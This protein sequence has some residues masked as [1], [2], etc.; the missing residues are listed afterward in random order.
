M[1]SSPKADRPTATEGIPGE[2]DCIARKR[3]GGTR[4]EIRRGGRYF[5]RFEFS[6]SALDVN[7]AT[8]CQ[9]LRSLDCLSLGWKA[10]ART[11]SVRFLDNPI[12][13]VLYNKTSSCLCLAIQ[14]K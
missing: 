10:S 14:T 11:L 3:I 8:P 6:V 5:T 9:L 2:T 4:E 13:A 12:S 1:Q 7:F